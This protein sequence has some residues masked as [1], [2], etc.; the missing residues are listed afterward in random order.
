MI[1]LFTGPSVSAA[2]SPAA[3]NIL[4]SSVPNGVESK[5]LK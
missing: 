5:T 1:I 3:F 2:I 4:F